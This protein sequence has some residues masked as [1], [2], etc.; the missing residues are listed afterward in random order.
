MNEFDEDALFREAMNDVSPLKDA[1]TTLWLKAP[2]TRPPKQ[3][4]ADQPDENF[5]TRGFLDVIPLTTKLEWKA[6]GIQQGVLD[7]LRKGEYRLDASLNLLRQPVETCRQA[8]FSFIRESQRQGLR[9][10]LI[11][12][13]KGRENESHANIVR[14]YLARWLAEFSEVQTFAT[15]QR[16]HGG[17]GA[18]Y[19]GLRKSEAARVENWERHA[20]RQQ[21]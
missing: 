5:L 19:V 18:L 10:L 21:R 7:K 9:N 13:G 6:E 16:Q 17:E 14:S 3:Q 1:T 2:S 20:R 11:I 8:L 4:Y 15:A 12:H